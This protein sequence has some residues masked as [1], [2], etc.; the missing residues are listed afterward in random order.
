MKK[1]KFSTLV[2]IC[3]GIIIASILISSFAFQNL[4]VF[5]RFRIFFMLSYIAVTVVEVWCIKNVNL[6]PVLKLF[7]KVHVAITLICYAVAI[8]TIGYIPE[9][10]KH[11]NV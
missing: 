2:L 7:I 1:I 9:T 6:N 8:I 10:L 4:H 3:V 11:L 5:Q